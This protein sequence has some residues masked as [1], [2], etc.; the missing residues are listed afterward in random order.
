MA[1]K[2]LVKQRAEDVQ[3]RIYEEGDTVDF[4]QK[5]VKNTVFVETFRDKYWKTSGVFLEKNKTIFNRE[6]RDLLNKMQK[7]SDKTGLQGIYEAI[8]NDKK[9]RQWIDEYFSNH[10]SSCVTDCS[11]S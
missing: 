2:A 4:D 10:R 7:G 1:D 5:P 3:D 8:T 11:S 9:G 6:L